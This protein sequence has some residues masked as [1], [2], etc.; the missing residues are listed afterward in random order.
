MSAAALLITAMVGRPSGAD[1]ASLRLSWQAPTTN[2][3]ATPLTD[4]SGYIIYVSTSAQACHGPISIA[5]PSPD[6]APSEGETVAY[7]MS[8]LTAG[9]RYSVAVSAV[10]DRG[11]ESQCSNEASG[12]AWVGF[13]ASPAIAD[14]GTTLVGTPVDRTFTVR[15]LGTASLSVTV[16]GPAPFSVVSGGSSTIAPGATRDV[17]VR[18]SPTIAAT[19][20]GNVNFTSDGDTVSRGVTATATLSDPPAPGTPS[21]TLMYAGKLRDRVGSSPVGLGGDGALDGTLT[22]TLSAAGGRA[23]T[24]LALQSSAPGSWDTDAAT[25]AWVL[26]VTRTL[27]GPLLNDPGTTAVSFT[28]ADG[29]TF[30]VFAADFAD[31]EFVPGTALTLSATF[32][33]GTT[34]TAVTFATA[35]APTAPPSLTLAYNGMLRD[36]VAPGKSGLGTDGRVDG[37]FTA[38]LTAPG[39][40]T[41]TRLALQSSAPGSW[42]TDRGTSAWILGVAN[43]LD[44]G[45]LND[46]GTLAVNFTVPDGGVFQLFAADFADSEFVVGS[47]LT[48]TATFSDGTTATAVTVAT[49]VTPLSLALKYEGAFRLFASDWAGIEFG[50]G[51]TLTLTATFSD[52]T[53]ATAVTVATDVAPLS[54]TLTYKGKVRD[55]VGQSPLGLGADGAPDGALTVKLSGAGG[56]TIARL[57]LQSSAPGRWDTDAGA[58]AWVLGVATTLDTHLLN[59]PVTMAV[60][61]TVAGG[62]TFQVFAADSRELLFSPGTTLTLTAT[63]LDGTTATAAVVVPPVLPALTLSYGGKLRDHVGANSI[64]LAADGALDGT[65]TVTLSAAGGRTITSL[66]LQSFAPAGGSWDTDAATAS[67]ALGVATALDTPLLN[68]PVTMAV[69]FAVPDGG[70]FQLF[71]SDFAGVKFVP[72]TRLTVTA[73]FSDGTT[74]SGETIAAV[75]PPSLTLVYNGKLRDRVGSS[76]LGRGADGAPD[77]TFTVTLAA[78]GGRTLTRLALQSDAPGSWDTDVATSTWLLGVATSLDGPLINDPVTMAVNFAV[79]DGGSFQLFAGDFAGLEFMPGRVL[80]LTAVFSDGTS[81][82]ATTVAVAVAPPPVLTLTYD[83]KLRDRVGTSDLAL[84]ADTELDA[85]FTAT[86]SAAGGRTITHLQLQSSAPG[87]WDTQA[88]TPAWVLGVA[89]TLDGTLLNDPTTMAVNF[90]VADGGS[91]YLFAADYADI[92]F[93]SGVTLALTALFSDGSSTTGTVTVP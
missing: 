43:T 31:S 82:S 5:V 48:L 56:R 34:A 62:G 6:A 17:V 79:P 88:A 61:F 21:L 18:F 68:D 10:D 60:N 77:G 41:I 8:G 13:T 33:D 85:T 64:G 3:D 63:F 73:V 74:A 84:A 11:L 1:A 19:F 71:A 76:N 78:A 80:T 69:N 65:F 81:A 52:G 24:R 14:F 91:F 25:S 92:E 32:S 47:V 46:P 7:Q 49:A 75:I 27:D 55:R 44:G 20:T 35:V 23:I 22:A 90:T 83:G 36:R 51:K 70:S 9:T 15:N 4:L 30:T 26:G 93:V 58:G 45:L 42:D 59:D 86:L 38:T 39:G 16:S 72:G 2:A 67:W 50:P 87:A 37:T 57:Q 66:Q 53:T 54:L 89:S 40:R 29:G 28:V 12:V